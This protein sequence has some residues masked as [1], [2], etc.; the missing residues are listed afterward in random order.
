MKTLTCALAAGALALA[1]PAVAYAAP[2]L[3]AGQVVEILD[4]DTIKIEDPIQ[5][6]V[7][8]RVLGVKAP[9]FSDP[10]FEEGCWGPES[11]Q[12][13]KDVLEGKK[14]ILVADPKQEQTTDSEGRVLAHVITAQGWNYGVEAARAGMVKADITDDNQVV[15]PEEI[16]IAEDTARGAGLG[17]WGAPCGGK[18]ASKRIAG[19]EAPKLGESASAAESEEAAD[20][21]DAKPDTRAAAADDAVAADEAEGD[22][23]EGAEATPARLATDPYTSCVYADFDGASPLRVGDPGWNPDLDPDGDGVACD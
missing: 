5:G 1:L 11:A 8:V 4:G 21:A 22:E 3:P 16:T 14:V 9:E 15:K 12:Y 6:D 17:L 20:E 2:K 7:Y 10:N 13:A 19:V 23:V 18:I